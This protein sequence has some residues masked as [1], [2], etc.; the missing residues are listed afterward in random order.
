MGGMGWFAMGLGTAFVWGAA[1]Q[2][3]PWHHLILWGATTSARQTT[4]KNGVPAR[5]QRSGSR[6][7]RTSK[8]AE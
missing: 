3:R 6:G 2:M 8:G 1:S 5:A 4:C 7:E